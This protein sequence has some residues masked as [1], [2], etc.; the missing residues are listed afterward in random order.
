M[1]F[2]FSGGMPAVREL[3]KPVTVKV[4]TPRKKPSGSQNGVPEGFI[5]AVILLFFYDRGFAI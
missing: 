3:L 4:R 2:L 1:P 5:H